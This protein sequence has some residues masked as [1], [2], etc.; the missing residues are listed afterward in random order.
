VDRD[1]IPLGARIAGAATPVVWPLENGRFPE[2]APWPES[3]DERFQRS[4]R[5]GIIPGA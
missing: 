1:R 2:P 5:M 4:R 3:D